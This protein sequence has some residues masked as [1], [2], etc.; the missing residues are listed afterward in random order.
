M[1]WEEKAAPSQGCC[2]SPDPEPH[3]R[4]PEPRKGGGVQGAQ[5]SGVRTHREGFQQ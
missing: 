5:P 2:P 1:G 3:S 4:S